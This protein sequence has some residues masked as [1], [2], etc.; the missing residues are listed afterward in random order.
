MVYWDMNK[1]FQYCYNNGLDLPIKGQVY[2]NNKTKYKYFCSKHKTSYLQAWDSH[3]LGRVGCNICHSNK[4]SRSKT[5]YSMSKVMKE[6]LLNKYDLPKRNQ[7][8]VTTKT[9]YIFVCPTHGEYE[10]SWEKHKLGQGC[11]KCKLDIVSK[12]KTKSCKQYYDECKENSI[13][14]PIEYYISDSTPIKHKCSKG[15]IY[16]QT[17]SNHL[18]GQGCPICKESHGEKF[19]RNYLDTNN[20]EYIPQKTFND[21]KD[22]TYLSYDYYLPEQKVLIEYQ[23]EQHFIAGG[24][25]KFDKDYFPTQQYHDK[26]KRD[27]AINNDYTLLEPTYKLDTQEKVNDYLDKHLQVLKVQQE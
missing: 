3:K 15:H 2:K 9:K 24:K 13:D 23:G 16:S 22:K 5:K 27:Y 6:C 7:K 21:L 17:P 12:L 25:G 1:M 11:S 14:L 18:R 20:I 19:I 8:Y 26:L 10:Q 4:I